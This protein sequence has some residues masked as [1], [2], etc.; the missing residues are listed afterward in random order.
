MNN[1]MIQLWEQLHNL[2]DT[3]DGS[4][5][6]I[7]LNNLTTD[8]VENIYLYLR[9][10]SKL[11]SHSSYFWS[12]ITD[13]EILVDSVENAASLVVNDEAECFHILI[14]GLCF[15]GTSIPDLGVFV[16]RDSICLD[17]RMGQEWGS[18]E[19][20]ALFILFSRIR[21]IAPLVEIEYLS[22]YSKIREQF[23][24]ALTKYW[25]MV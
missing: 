6:D 14:G 20:G 16:S 17:Y 4:L 15:G 11:I 18:T 23:K 7:E 19:L 21:E 22:S 24:S 10:S 9:L 5:P 1:I 13:E 3:N 25:D 2:F 12:F 8:Q